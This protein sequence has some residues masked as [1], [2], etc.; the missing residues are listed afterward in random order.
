MCK[1]LIHNELSPTARPP[2]KA[3]KPKKARPPPRPAL[4]L[5]VKLA[6]CLDNFVHERMAHDI[7]I[8]EADYADSLYVFYQFNTF[9]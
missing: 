2:K 3:L 5:S 8:A 9:E 4:L 7:V 1:L 6:E